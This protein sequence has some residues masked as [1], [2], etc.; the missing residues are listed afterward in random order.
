MMPTLHEN[1]VLI[2]SRVG[3]EPENG[4]VVIVQMPDAVSH[5]LVKRVIAT[6]GQTVRIDF[7]AWE[8][9]VDGKLVKEDYIRKTD[10]PMKR[11]E[12]GNYFNRIDAERKIYEE[13]VPEHCVF[14]LGDNRNN[15][16]DSRTLG[17][18]DERFVVGEVSFRLLPLSSI[19]DVD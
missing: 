12:I 15:S 6:S 18:I 3:Y 4:D 19:G 13:V 7:D 10:E 2:I 16:K 11:Y 1:D 14:V 9:Y 5:P 17:F 8:I